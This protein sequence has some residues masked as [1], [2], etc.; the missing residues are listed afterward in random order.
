MW[1]YTNVAFAIINDAFVCSYSSRHTIVPGLNCSL[2]W[3]QLIFTQLLFTLYCCI[4][5][6]QAL[7]GK[8]KKRK[9]VALEISNHAMSHGGWTEL[10]ASSLFSLE[11]CSVYCPSSYNFSGSS[12]VRWETQKLISADCENSVIRNNRKKLVWMSG[13]LGSN[14]DF[15]TK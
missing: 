2:P 5:K 12:P 13:D 7:W 11:L 1:A 10:S 3:S 9:S 15:I 4:V 6:W 8:C 14:S